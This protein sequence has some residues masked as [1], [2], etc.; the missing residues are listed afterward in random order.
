M[1]RNIIWNNWSIL[2]AYTWELVVQK[3]DLIRVKKFTNCNKKKIMTMSLEIQYSLNQKSDFKNISLRPY[4]VILFLFFLRG[5]PKK[6]KSIC[7]LP[8]TLLSDW[9]IYCVSL[10]YPANISQFCAVGLNM[11]S[12]F[13][14]L[15]LLCTL[16]PLP[17]LPFYQK[18]SVRKNLF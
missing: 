4:N 12:G 6:V 11:P 10:S 9:P 5:Q 17:H 8:F 15:Y 18:F 1:I 16:T 2:K 7:I 13:I 3:L 14:L